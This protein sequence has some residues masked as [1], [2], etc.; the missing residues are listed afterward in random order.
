ML[1]WVPFAPQLGV[2]GAGEGIS[3]GV[4]GVGGFGVGE[5]VAGHR[6][7][8]MGPLSQ[9]SQHCE[10]L[11]RQLIS[12]VGGGVGDGV[13]GVGLSVGG[14]G[15]HAGL[16]VGE[17]LVEPDGP[18]DVGK[19]VF[20]RDF[21][22]IGGVVVGAAVVV[23]GALRR[24]RDVSTG[25][26]Q[27]VGL[28]VGACVGGTGVGGLGVGGG[29]GGKPLGARR[30]LLIVLGITQLNRLGLLGVVHTGVGD[31]QM[32]RRRLS[33]NGRLKLYLKLVQVQGSREPGFASPWCSVMHSTGVAVVGAVVVVVV[34]AAVVVVVVGAAVVVVVVGAVVVGGKGVRKGVVAEQTKGPSRKRGTIS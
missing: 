28:G 18:L 5:L 21:G 23:T 33:A 27:R 1:I 3:C 7:Q 30:L 34:G 25:V 24:R 26:G 13:H 2:G 19:G 31:V 12:G 9:R 6:V 15:T 32:R 4:G 20:T 8:L 16:G 11:R 29:V 10:T 14:V 17:I 22:G